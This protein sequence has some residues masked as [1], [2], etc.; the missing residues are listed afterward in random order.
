MKNSIKTLFRV[1]TSLPAALTGGTLVEPAVDQ[2][3]R[4]VVYP[5]QVR[6]LTSTAEVTLS[7]GDAAV[8]LSGV[9]STFHDLLEVTCANTSDAAINISLTDDGSVVR[10]LEL[11]ANDTKGFTFPGPIPQSASGGTWYADMEDVTGT[12]VR[13]G[14][15]FIKSS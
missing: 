8:L 6:E 14:A 9:T 10:N 5:Y 1:L 13:V 3:G 12:T 11:P 2:I 15:T 7:D 4:T